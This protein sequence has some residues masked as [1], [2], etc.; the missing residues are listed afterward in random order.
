[1]SKDCEDSSTLAFEQLRL[2]LAAVIQRVCTNDAQGLPMETVTAE[3]GRVMVALHQFMEQHKE[4]PFY[5]G[6]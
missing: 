1:M 5:N 2:K 3:A 4:T 6:Y